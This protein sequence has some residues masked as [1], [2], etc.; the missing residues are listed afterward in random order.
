MGKFGSAGVR[1]DELIG[2]QSRDAGA[3]G[4]AAPKLK[5]K[6]RFVRLQRAGW[7]G[8][9]GWNAAAVGERGE[10]GRLLE[11]VLI[12]YEKATETAQEVSCYCCC[13]NKG[14]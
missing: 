10:D 2:F 13:T 14:P 5:L 4:S 12:G 1:G 6:M 3:R 8:G 7:G 9:C 11:A